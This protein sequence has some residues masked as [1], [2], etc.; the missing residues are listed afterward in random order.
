MKILVNTILILITSL[1]LISC[2]NNSPTQGG[3][4]LEDSYF[5][6]T[7]IDT[8]AGYSIE[9]LYAVDAQTFFAAGSK[10]YKFSNGT[11]IRMN[12]SDTNFFGKIV[13]AYNSN[14]AVFSNASSFTNDN[15]ILQIYNGSSLEEHIV[16]T[17]GSDIIDISILEP[18]KILCATQKRLFLFSSG[19]IIDIPLP[20]S[21][22]VSTFGNSNNQ[23]LVLLSQNGGYS[24]YQYLNQNLTFIRRDTMYY[25][26]YKLKMDFIRARGIS[27]ELM[28]YDYL[29]GT[30]W[31]QMF[32]RSYFKF[33]ATF[34]ILSGES[35]NFFVYL[36][37]DSSYTRN[38]QV[39]NGT[40]SYKESNFPNDLNGSYD[41]KI[42]NYTDNTFFFYYGNYINNGVILKASRIKF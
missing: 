21:S 16:S 18:G 7:T 28:S 42:S 27:E 2:S 5:S 1:I 23:Q 31:N 24:L 36:S 37:K 11:K 29:D 32:T 40:S 22:R 34:E 35:K 13:R 10:S 4:T 9:D 41:K 26:P 15:V 25:Q 19:N 38:L 33:I 8:S 20:A 3:I 17:N 6:W 14:Y 39:W 12:F 30:N